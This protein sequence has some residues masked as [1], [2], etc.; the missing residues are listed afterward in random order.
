[1]STQVIISCLRDTLKL[2][3]APGVREGLEARLRY[4]LNGTNKPNYQNT[5]PACEKS[6]RTRHRAAV[7]KYREIRPLIIRMQAEGLIGKEIVTALRE[8]GV[9][10]LQGKPYGIGGIQYIM[11]RT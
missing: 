6:A 8:A 11:R 7:R 10:N 4:W 3:L 9:T 5:T 2:D 1:M